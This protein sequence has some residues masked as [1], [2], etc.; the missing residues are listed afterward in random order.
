MVS[1]FT[2]LIRR[3]PRLQDSTSRHPRRPNHGRLLLRL[4][5]EGT[6]PV[7]ACTRIDVCTKGRL[8]KCSERTWNPRTCSD[9]RHAVRGGQRYV[10]LG[11][12]RAARKQ[13]GGTLVNGLAK[14]DQKPKDVFSADESSVNVP[15]LEFG[16]YRSYFHAWIEGNLASVMNVQRYVPFSAWRW[17]ALKTALYEDKKVTHQDVIQVRPLS[18]SPPM[19]NPGH[20]WDHLAEK[21]FEFFLKQTR[22]GI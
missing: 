6:T 14:L 22:Y 2:G 1:A 12:T 16:H 4:K 21:Y 18:S 17:I 10:Q 3:A 20:D 11:N 15:L 9:H 7:L 13:R 8:Q 19:N 5:R